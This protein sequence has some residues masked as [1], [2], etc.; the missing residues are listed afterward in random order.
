[1]MGSNVDFTRP[2][3]IYACSQKIEHMHHATQ[4]IFRYSQHE[5]RHCFASMGNGSNTFRPH[6]SVMLPFW[7]ES[8][9]KR[10]VRMHF[11]MVHGHSMVSTMT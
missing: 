11:Y 3:N 9:Q 4:A 1:M 8:P 6:M 10:N 5:M 7:Y 2:K